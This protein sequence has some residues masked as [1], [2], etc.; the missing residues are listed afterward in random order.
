MNPTPP[1]TS[2]S[3]WQ[4]FSERFLQI[5]HAYAGWL[6]SITWKRFIL[7]SLALIV[8]MAILHDIPPFSWTYTEIISDEDIPEPP[9]PPRKLKKNKSEKSSRSDSEG[10]NISIDENGVHIQKVPSTKAP[11]ASAAQQPGSAPTAPTP[12]A[13]PTVPAPTPETPADAS[14]G[15]NIQLKLPPDVDAEE[16]W[17]PTGSTQQTRAGWTPFEGWQ[18][19]GRVTGVTLRGQ[20]VYE[21][22]TILA[23]PGSGRNVVG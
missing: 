15:V 8:S 14:G 6:V 1:T 16:A 19:R 4:R 9:T 21:N 3:P 7:L 5:F 18:L 20:R 22:G 2:R 17:R 13:A 23:Q 12:P 11:A 10:V